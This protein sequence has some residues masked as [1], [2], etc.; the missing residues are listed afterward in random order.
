MEQGVEVKVMRSSEEIIQ[1]VRKLVEQDTP[2]GAE[3]FA[4]Q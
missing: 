3:N 1:F 2:S 4:S